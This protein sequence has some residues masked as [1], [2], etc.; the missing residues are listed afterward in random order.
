MMTPS[1]QDLRAAYLQARAEADT[2]RDQWEAFLPI[3]PITDR[4]V[5]PMTGNIE[6]AHEVLVEAEANEAKARD[7]LRA[8]LR[9]GGFG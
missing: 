5:P 1:L 7:A 8:V 9:P 6:R 4:Q 3:E 2:A